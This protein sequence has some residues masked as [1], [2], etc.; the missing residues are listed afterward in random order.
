MTHGSPDSALATRDRGPHLP[1]L[2]Q[3]HLGEKGISH[4]IK[5]SSAVGV[6]D[7]VS[8]ADPMANSSPIAGARAAWE[9]RTS[10]FSDEGAS[11]PHTSHRDPAHGGAGVR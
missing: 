8:D 4:P 9:I 10:G 1:G 11:L 2:R 6:H 3:P 5:G 7:R